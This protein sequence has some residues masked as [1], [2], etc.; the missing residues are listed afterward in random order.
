MENLSKQLVNKSIESFILGLEIY[1][2]PTIK[3][4]IE[5]FS[6]FICNAWELML[7]VVVVEKDSVVEN[8]QL[9]VVLV[10]GYNGT[11][12]RIRY[13]DDQVILIPESNNPNHY[14]QV[15]SAKDEVEI[16]GKVVASVKIFD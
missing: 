3:Y 14:P 11:V 13:K 16:V 8:G 5:G 4:R 6:F 7:K 15:Y 2:K 10:N 12:K 1:N 9:G